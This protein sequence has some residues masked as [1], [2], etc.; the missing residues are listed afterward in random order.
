MLSGTSSTW[1]RALSVLAVIFAVIFFGSQPARAD[2]PPSVADLVAAAHAEDTA[3]ALATPDPSKTNVGL[4]VG[5]QPAMLGHLATAKCLAQICQSPIANEGAYESGLQACVRIYTQAHPHGITPIDDTLEMEANPGHAI[6][7]PVILQCALGNLKFPPPAPPAPRENFGPTPPPIPAP[8][9]NAAWHVAD[10]GDDPYAD[11]PKAAP[12][13][14]PRAVAVPTHSTAATR[15]ARSAALSRGVPAASMFAACLDEA[16]AKVRIVDSTE[17]TATTP[18]KVVIVAQEGGLGGDTLLACAT[19]IYKSDVGE[20]LRGNTSIS[21]FPVTI[22]GGKITVEPARLARG[23]NRFPTFKD[24]TGADKILTDAGSPNEKFIKD[25]EDDSA[26]CKLFLA[27]QSG[28]RVTLKGPDPTAAP[29]APGG[30]NNAGGKPDAKP[31]DSPKGVHLDLPS[32]ND[33]GVKFADNSQIDSVDSTPLNSAV[34]ESPFNQDSN[35]TS[36]LEAK[37]HRLRSMRVRMAI[38]NR[39][40]FPSSPNPSRRNRRDDGGR[41]AIEPDCSPPPQRGVE[42][43]L[44]IELASGSYREA[45]PYRR[46][47][48]YSSPDPHPPRGQPMRA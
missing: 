47:F 32:P 18:R 1:W 8:I 28:E 15:A 11:L 14:A 30:T 45:G 20:I 31:E 46:P 16:G 43:T 24:S 36:S 37:R 33:G 6:T 27:V 48:L 42:N 4:R 34:D 12:A 39:D 26:G 7:D 23:H 25:C 41:H 44:Y 17:Q 29:A 40:R 2:E 3:L 21:L 5:L 9:I 35:E 10:T 22:K 13:P 38:L 19:G